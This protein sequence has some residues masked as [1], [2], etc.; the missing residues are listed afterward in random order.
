[1][2][3]STTGR[4]HLELVRVI[5]KGDLGGTKAELKRRRTAQHDEERSS[6]RDL[7][8]WVNREL[9]TASMEEAGMQSVDASTGDQQQEP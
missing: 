4:R 9:L 1:M 8:E 5:D 6:L 7:A 3:H 2:R